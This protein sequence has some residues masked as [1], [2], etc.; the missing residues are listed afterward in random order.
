MKR[1]RGKMPS[2]GLREE[3]KKKR[4]IKQRSKGKKSVSKK[5]WKRGKSGRKIDEGKKNDLYAAIEPLLL[6]PQLWKSVRS[7][8]V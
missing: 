3:G 1:G 4:S 2:G 6:P 7:K 8:S 5:G